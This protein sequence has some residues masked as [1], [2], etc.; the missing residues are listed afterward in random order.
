MNQRNSLKMIKY[1]G[2]HQKNKMKK[3]KKTKIVKNQMEIILMKERKS[4]KMKRILR[5]SKVKM[6]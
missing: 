1:K 2:N 4:T 5:V 6:L 3:K